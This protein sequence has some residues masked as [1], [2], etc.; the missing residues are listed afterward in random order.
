MELKGIALIPSNNDLDERLER[1]LVLRIV[2]TKPDTIILVLP[3]GHIFVDAVSVDYFTKLNIAG[4]EYPCNLG[5]LDDLNRV[6]IREKIPAVFINPEKRD[7]YNLTINSSDSVKTFLGLLD[8]VLPEYKICQITSAPIGKVELLETGR[9]IRESVQRDGHSAYMVVFSELI[10]QNNNSEF[11]NLLNSCIK[12]DDYLPILQYMPTPNEEDQYNNLLIGIGATEKLKTKY[13]LL[14]KNNQD[15]FNI[16]FVVETLD[17]SKEEDKKV[18]F[19]N[20]SIIDVWKEVRKE[21]RQELLKAESVLQKMVRKTVE[22]WVNERKKLNFDSYAEII[23]DSSL[24]QRLKNQRTGVFVTILKDNKPRGTMGTINPV[25]D[26]IAE[27]IINNAIEAAAF[28]PTF[29]PVTPQELDELEYEVSV[30]NPLES[31]DDSKDL[32]PKKYGI[33]VEQGL[34]RGIVLPNIKE[35]KTVEQ[36]IEVAKE[37][38][39]IDDALDAWDPLLIKRFTVETF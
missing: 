36:Q 16:N 33:V 31:V 35:I 24:I 23:G 4:K 12:S 29:I 13:E 19:T 32:D 20:N 1:D 17:L 22:L 30:L 10:S 9:C 38:A 14:S 6:L 8:K 21:Q 26:N 18:D 11:F 39:N 34:K 7:N 27:E 28:D 25:M 5:I 37:R 15:I 3:E 2:S